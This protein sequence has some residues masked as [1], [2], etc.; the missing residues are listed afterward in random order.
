MNL[1]IA[2]LLF[3]FFLVAD[4]SSSVSAQD[5][6][7]DDLKSRYRWGSIYFA[8]DPI[9][10]LIYDLK[11]QRK[12]TSIRM[13][14]RS[15]VIPLLDNFLKLNMT[16]GR[17]SSV[18]FLQINLHTQEAG[19]M[20]ASDRDG[21]I[22][23]L[24]WSKEQVREI[25]ILF[26]QILVKGVA[27]Q[28]L[29]DDIRNGKTSM[30][31]AWI[32][33]SDLSRDELIS[34]EKLSILLA[35]YRTGLQK[36][37]NERDVEGYKTMVAWAIQGRFDSLIKDS[38][39]PDPEVL[40]GHYYENPYNN[41][42]LEKFKS[43][44]EELLLALNWKKGEQSTAMADR[45]EDLVAVAEWLYTSGDFDRAHDELKQAVQIEPQNPKAFIL[46]A[47]IY[48]QKGEL[49]AAVTFAKSALRVDP[50]NANAHELLG[51]V[52][53]RQNKT[54]EAITSLKSA[55]FWDAKLIDANLLLARIYLARADREKAMIYINNAIL[56]D[57]K[58]KEV[59]QLQQ[60]L[61]AKP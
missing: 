48:F 6:R 22:K 33:I 44:N 15:S 53:L 2:S 11:D 18:A 37:D 57:A 28:N 59:I 40:L 35:A 54:E 43:D 29:L 14:D 45:Y 10:D 5:N 36:L 50:S 42:F 46:L 41:V 3:V 47:R 61:S 13:L 55:L 32:H 17:V 23:P 31:E 7:L 4:C 1:R 9:C 24:Q 20:K 56:L 30:F 52:Y 16:G 51:R 25:A 49:D 39:A 19:Y 34:S 60:E 8:Y 12:L 58:N 21:V 38:K 27:F 26:D